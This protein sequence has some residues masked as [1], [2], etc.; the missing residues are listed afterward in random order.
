MSHSLSRATA[1]RLTPHAPSRD[2]S[3]EEALGWLRQ[4]PVETYNLPVLLLEEILKVRGDKPMETSNDEA[5]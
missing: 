2:L 1:T 3:A 4:A 5:F